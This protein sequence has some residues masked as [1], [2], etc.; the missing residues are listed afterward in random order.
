MRRT[1]LPLSAQFGTPDQARPQSMMIHSNRRHERELPDRSGTA[2][3]RGAGLPRSRV[4]DQRLGPARLPPADSVLSAVPG[5]GGGK[6]RRHAVAASAGTSRLATGPH[7][8]AGNRDRVRCEFRF[9]RSLHAGL[10]QGV[11]HFAKC[12]VQTTEVW[13]AALAGRNVPSEERGAAAES[14]PVA[15][16]ARFAKSDAEFNAIL[17]DVRNRGA[18]QDTF[19]DALCEPPETFTFGGKFAHV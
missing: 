4:R 15:L 14:T 6:P 8:T 10:P 5:P 1:C 19:V 12:L 9:L 17:S 7:A 2:F 13:T 11:P 3:R 18:W 16:L